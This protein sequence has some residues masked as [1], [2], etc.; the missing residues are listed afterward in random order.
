MRRL[1][2]PLLLFALPSFA[3]THTWIGAVSNKISEPLNWSGGSPVGDDNADLLFAGEAATYNVINDVPGLHF[4][5]I[6]TSQK[7]DISGAPF[8]TKDGS[9]DGVN[10]GLTF[11]SD[12][13]FEGSLII[14][15][16]VVFVGAIGGNGGV[17]ITGNLAFTGTR[18]NTYTGG[19]VV[20]NGILSLNRPGAISIPGDVTI[21]QTG[22]SS[23]IG[24][25]ASEQI[26]DTATVSL[27]GGNLAIDTGSTETIHKL[28]AERPVDGGTL[29]VGS[30]EILG[31]IDVSANIRLTQS[32]LTVP[33]GMLF[34]TTTDA[35]LSVPAGAPMVFHGPGMLQIS[36]NYSEPTIL[37]DGIRA[38]IHVPNSNVQLISG[39]LEG[40]TVGSLAADGG[41]ISYTL[42]A[43]KDIRLSPNVRFTA[44]PNVTLNGTFTAGGAVLDPPLDVTGSTPGVTT[45][46]INNK[47]AQP[48]VGTFKNAPEGAVI[49]NRYM[50]SYKGGDGNDI[51]CKELQRPL[52]AVAISRA[53]SPAFVGDP[54][55]ITATVTGNSGVPTGNV[56][57]R[58]RD[59]GLIGTVPL[60]DGKASATW[61]FPTIDGFVQAVYEGDS[62]YARSNEV[63]SNA[64]LSYHKPVITSV[65]PSDF[66][67]GTVT[68]VIVRGSN[69]G[70]TS[71]VGST[72]NVLRN[73]T[74]VSSSEIHA[75]LD[76]SALRAATSIDLTVI[77][78][79]RGASDPFSLAVRAAAQ[80]PSPIGFADDLTYVS[81]TTTKNGKA[82]LV[83]SAGASFTYLS[84]DDGDGFVRWLWPAKVAE[85]V[86]A[87]VDVAA[88][89]FSVRGRG[90][91]IPQQS[92]FPASTFIRDANGAAT[93]FIIHL[94]DGSSRTW[95]V[96][97]VRPGVG[98][99]RAALTD[100]S[101]NDEDK[102]SNGLLFG[103]VSSMS[104]MVGSN[105][106]APPAAFAAGDVV[107][108][109][110]SG[111]TGLVTVPVYAAKLGA[112]LADNDG[113]T[114]SMFATRVNATENQTAH[115]TVMRI[116]N[117]PATVHYRTL[118]ATAYS[119]NDYSGT[120][121]SVVELAPG[122]IFKTIDVPIVNDNTWTSSRAFYVTLIGASGTTLGNATSTRVDIV[123]DDPTPKI[124]FAGPDHRTVLVGLQPSAINIPV[125]VNGTFNAPVTF[126]WST[127]QYGPF[128]SG[129]V[130]F[131]PGEREKTITITLP[132][133][134]QVI[135]TVPPPAKLVIFNTNAVRSTLTL[136][137]RA[138]TPIRANDLTVNENA[139]TAHIV[140]TLDSP[141]TNPTSITYSTADGT[142]KAGADY[143]AKSGSVQFN[144]G[145][146]QAAID[147][148]I[149]DDSAVEGD[150][151]F[152]VRFSDG[153]SQK[154][155]TVVIVDD[156][157][158]NRAHVSIDD[159]ATVTEGDD[160]TATAVSV[161][162]Q[163]A[164]TL[165]VSIHYTTSDVTAIGGRD[166]QPLDDV[167]T[168]APGETVK[169][170]A[171]PI[172]GNTIKQPDKTFRVTLS[173]PVNA[174]IDN[175]Q[176]TITIV[177]D[178]PAI[179]IRRHGS[180]H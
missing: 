57:F 9:I 66:V 14:D 128:Q 93:R 105:T 123:D 65:E 125:V 121:D 62:V 64:S 108:A 172:F 101:S 92:P 42:D 126:P 29:V 3:A 175:A 173:A 21:A 34:R 90:N 139:G 131:Q 109:M 134:P 15:G 31:S 118:D 170:I 98:A 39:I 58:D 2:L 83:A 19:T 46:L 43:A 162:L 143:V 63:F 144:A 88:G 51:T 111:M 1:L 114:V 73:V 7:Y 148:P 102:T 82:A 5:R 69:F 86:F 168:F 56:T 40:S 26:A 146:S 37:M 85:T 142:A 147:V 41:T 60:S 122:E 174:V 95:L 152:T 61:T 20:S 16:D 119:P 30:I 78:S 135:D 153:V 71:Q 130:T 106:P 124:D 132:P 117:G 159:H 47:S 54:I 45:T 4:H 154:R 96:L 156:E 59:F 94:A 76:L 115:V 84:D 180:R 99:W 80:P 52:P 161:R 48:V 97:W 8:T 158:T 81:F 107:I 127:A 166:Y 53:P 70:T 164:S 50:V 113:G 72:F 165:P 120:V 28:I 35:K 140:V 100:G 103:S 163:A 116:G 23:R 27:L 10:G 13:T 171:L 137:L 133:S 91:A 160:F 138:S 36:G 33:A 17:S 32:T 74:N 49:W 77:D 136:E 150:E 141:A 68:S 11:W 149:L 25:S 157:T 38:G 110:P 89:T 12:V 44:N 176:S 67:A 145:Q 169:T 177:D 87:A 178:D 151:T 18:S 112:E 155:I 104:P 6:S 22:G 167:L 79:T 179:P 24:I 75:T 129:T 55:T